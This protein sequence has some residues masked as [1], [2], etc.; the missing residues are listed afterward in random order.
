VRVSGDEAARANRIAGL[1]PH[2]A[3]GR[4]TVTLT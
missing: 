1:V 2:L 4:V 3:Y